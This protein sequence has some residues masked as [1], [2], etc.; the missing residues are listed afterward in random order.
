[1][2]IY[3][4]YVS[5]LSNDFSY[6][7]LQ[8]VQLGPHFKIFGIVLKLKQVMFWIE[9]YMFVPACLK[10][11]FG[12]SRLWL[13]LLMC[14]S[15]HTENDNFYGPVF[16]NTIIV[17]NVFRVLGHKVWKML[18]DY[19]MC[20]IFCDSFLKT[21]LAWFSFHTHSEKNKIFSVLHVQY[22]YGI[23]LFFLNCMYEWAMMAMWLFVVLGSIQF[24]WHSDL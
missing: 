5:N 15:F 13:H 3:C 2:M 7:N 12:C 16:C 1:M 23:V 11:L 24:L 19:C 4:F 8:L 18:T 9:I 10:Y 14:Y 6:N 22:V 21:F 20:P 17:W